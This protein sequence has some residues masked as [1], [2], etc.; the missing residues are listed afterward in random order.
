MKVEAT[1]MVVMTGTLRTAVR[2]AL[3]SS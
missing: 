1:V 2:R 3:L